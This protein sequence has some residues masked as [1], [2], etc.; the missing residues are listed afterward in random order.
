MA[1]P[2]NHIA[3][4][5]NSNQIGC[6]FRVAT[7]SPE[8]SDVFLDLCVVINKIAIAARASGS[9]S[10]F[11]SAPVLRCCSFRFSSFGFDSILV[12]VRIPLHS[13]LTMSTEQKGATRPAQP[14]GHHGRAPTTFMAQGSRA[15][16]PPARRA[17]CD[18]RRYI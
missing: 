7:I 13:T 12:L 16:V 14:P 15:V 2:G 11:R 17:I 4:K 10:Q 3:R 5:F 8:L 18:R 6:T 9:F 1:P